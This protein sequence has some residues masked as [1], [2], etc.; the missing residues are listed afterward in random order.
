MQ[1]LFVPSPRTSDWH[2]K[3][4]PPL[5]QKSTQAEL[6]CSFQAN[7]RFQSSQLSLQIMLAPTYPKGFRQNFSMLHVRWFRR[8]APELTNNISSHDDEHSSIYFLKSP[9]SSRA[10]AVQLL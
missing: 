4:A 5:D 1:T 8:F 10:S 3:K 9:I 7:N 2:L 6:V